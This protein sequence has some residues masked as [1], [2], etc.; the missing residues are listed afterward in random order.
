MLKSE[1]SME[2]GMVMSM[3]LNFMCTHKSKVGYR[4]L[5]YPLLYM[6]S[7]IAML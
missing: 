4:A 3:M 2:T 7:A 1:M 6:L 5:M